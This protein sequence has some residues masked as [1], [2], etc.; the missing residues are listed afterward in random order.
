MLGLADLIGPGGK[1]L[2]R[3]SREA[4]FDSDEDDLASDLEFEGEDEEEYSGVEGDEAS[5]EG[6]DGE[7]E[8]PSADEAVGLRSEGDS[9][10]SEQHSYDDEAARTFRTF[11]TEPRV[12]STLAGR[13]S[14]PEEPTRY[15]PPQVRAAQLAAK[16][17]GNKE[18]SE[19]HHLLVRRLQGLLNR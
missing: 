4:A 5:E 9:E 1:G 16:A 19:A 14:T 2:K 10:V 18:K 8:G 15:I 12:H 11:E 3:D 6:S 13:A 7:D 17:A